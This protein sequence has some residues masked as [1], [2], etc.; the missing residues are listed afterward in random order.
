MEL[1]L[2]GSGMGHIEEYSFAN[3]DAIV[4]IFLNQCKYFEN[5]CSVW[6]L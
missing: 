5:S 2:S 6:W 1:V 3:F 4:G